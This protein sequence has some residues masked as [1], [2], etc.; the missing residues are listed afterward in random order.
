MELIKI[1]TQE[2]SLVKPYMNDIMSFDTGLVEIIVG[3]DLAKEKGATILNHKINGNTYWTFSPREKRKV[4]EEQI[5]SFVFEIIE[6]LTK[7]VQINNLNPLDF[8]NQTEYLQEL[9]KSITGCGGYLYLNKIYIYCDNNI[10]HIDT[11]LLKFLSWDIL[12][13]I[14]NL[15]EIKENPE[16]PKVLKDLDIKYI[17]YLNGKK[18]NIISNICNT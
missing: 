1:T 13:E 9:K 4:F 18:S 17:P 15:I 8:N 11:D 5:K 6:G 7:N 10:Y 16:I 12:D 14:K 2:K 3:W